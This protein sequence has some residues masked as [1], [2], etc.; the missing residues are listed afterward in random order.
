MFYGSVVQDVYV[1][2]STIEICVALAVISFNDELSSIVK[3]YE[4]LNVAS[5]NYTLEFC[6]KKNNPRDV[7]IKRN[8]SVKVKKRF[9][10]FHA[11]KKGFIDSTEEKEGPLW[12]WSF[13]NTH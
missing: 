6:G 13:F 11:K 3:V 12:S 7:V 10:H 2:R 8:S 1:G 5:G 4:E 9:K